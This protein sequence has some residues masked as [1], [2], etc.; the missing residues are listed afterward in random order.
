MTRFRLS[1][2]AAAIALLLVASVAA[3]ARRISVN[4]LEDGEILVQSQRSIVIRSPGGDMEKQQDDAVK[5]LYRMAQRECALV[6]DTIGSSCELAAINT[7][8]SANEDG[9]ERSPTVRASGNFSLK[10]K[11]K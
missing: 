11:L 10:I 2:T 7:N 5:L 9:G 8:V 3:E 1:A 6:L 4:E